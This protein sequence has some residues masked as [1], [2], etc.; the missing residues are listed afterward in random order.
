VIFDWD[1]EALKA[2]EASTGFESLV[3][4]LTNF[5]LSICSEYGA[6]DKAKI[7]VELWTGVISEIS[8]A[9]VVYSQVFEHLFYCRTLGIV[10]FMEDKMSGLAVAILGILH[11]HFPSLKSSQGRSQSLVSMISSLHT[12]IATKPLPTVSKAFLLTLLKTMDR[13]LY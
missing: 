4:I 12:N 9:Q 5:S 11:S 8:S 7:L 2:L 10:Q 6:G 3:L 13:T 1:L